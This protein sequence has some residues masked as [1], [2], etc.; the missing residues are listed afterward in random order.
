MFNPGDRVRWRDPNDHSGPWPNPMG[1]TITGS[2]QTN[3]G[4]GSVTVVFDEVCGVVGYTWCCQENQLELDYGMGGGSAVVNVDMTSVSD[5]LN[6][7]NHT[8][9]MSSNQIPQMPP[10]PT[11]YQED[12][13][14]LFSNTNHNMGAH[15]VVENTNEFIFSKK[16]YLELEK[17]CENDVS[18]P[19]GEVVVIIAEGTYKNSGRIAKLIRNS[20][21]KEAVIFDSG[22]KTANKDEIFW[23]ENKYKVIKVDNEVLTDLIIIEECK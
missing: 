8:I 13:D 6:A 10:A 23:F 15:V 11:I 7:L 9:E 19:E 20:K 4:C 18:F 17:K 1:Q 3:N 5:A 12:A 21:G 16:A 2:L 22:I 14:R